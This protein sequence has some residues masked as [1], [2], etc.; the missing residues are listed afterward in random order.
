[1]S[2]LPTEDNDVAGAVK[3]RK[4]GRIAIMASRPKKSKPIEPIESPTQSTRNSVT[5][6]TSTPDDEGEVSSDDEVDDLLLSD[7][8]KIGRNMFNTV[9]L[10]ARRMAIYYLYKYVHNSPEESLWKGRN[11][12]AVQI[13]NQ[14]L[15]PRT[16]ELRNLCNTMRVIKAYEA[17]GVEYYGEAEPRKEWGHYLIPPNSYQCQLI[18]DLLEGEFGFSECTHFVNLY[19]EEQ[20]DLTHVGRST[21]YLA[22]SRLKPTVTKI[23]KRQQGSLDL[24]SDWCRASY[25]WAAQM[26]LMFRIAIVL[27]ELWIVAGVPR[28]LDVNFVQKIDIESTQFWDET[29]KRQRIGKLK[30]GT[31]VQY[32]FLRNEEGKLDLN[33]GQLSKR[34][35]EL[36]MKYEKEARFS[37]GMCLRLDTAGNVVMD[38]DGRPLG[39]RLELFEYSEQKIVS[40]SDYMAMLKLVIKEAKDFKP[41]KPW[42]DD[43]RAE[44]AFYTTD[45]VGS[46]KGLNAAAIKWLKKENVIT[47]KDYFDFFN[48][49]VD[50]R[51]NFVKAVKGIS[52]EKQLKAEA[53]AEEAIDG[54]PVCVDHRKHNVSKC[55]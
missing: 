32:R 11:G 44:G 54:P 34:G 9:H 2:E 28:N 21:V 45:L 33:H 22:A 6:T 5:V 42:L 14:L 48:R 52:K 27:P 12:I 15:M 49:R 18:A 36:K 47:V 8:D 26:L 43:G 39:D 29:H 1:M 53:V 16:S 19:R 23:K 17:N 7:Y 13:R 31:N 37:T 24:K 51:N 20:E 10:R 25:L 55:L 46:L 3:K 30:N 50:R 35:T 40:Q 38:E 41:N 4:S